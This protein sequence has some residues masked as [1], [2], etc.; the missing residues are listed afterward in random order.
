RRTQPLLASA[1]VRPK[2]AEEAAVQAAPDRVRRRVRQ[3]HPPVTPAEAGDLALE[4]FGGARIA[5]GLAA[6]GDRPRRRLIGGQDARAA[7]AEGQG[8]PPVLSGDRL[9]VN[10]R[11][12]RE[13]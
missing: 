10:L 7:V 9:S 1:Q 5:R 2:V 8:A 6:W 4:G 11:Q 13:E 12:S 3:D